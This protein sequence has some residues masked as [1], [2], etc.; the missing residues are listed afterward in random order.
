[1]NE[2]QSKDLALTVASILDAKKAL[3]VKI[4]HVTEKTVIADYFVIA[5]GMNR[6]QVNAMADEVE[7]KLDTEKGVKPVNVEG[8]G[9]GGWVLLDY[10]SV[11]VHV[12]NPAS[13]DFYNLEKLFAECEEVPF[14]TGAE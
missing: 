4:L 10:G 3:D 7:Y 8:R 6:T 13:R 1:M 14:E 5:G 9:Q 12:F 2:L 11:I